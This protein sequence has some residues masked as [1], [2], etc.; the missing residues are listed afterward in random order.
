MTVPLLVGPWLSE[1][2]YEALYWTAFVRWF[3][4]EYEVD[5]GRLV[6]VSRGG[7]GTWYADITSNYVELLDLFA[8]DDFAERNRR[9]LEAGDQKQLAEA[10]FDAEILR[11]LRASG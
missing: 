11:R 10:E 4:R 3:V 7:V 1:V 5:P 9:R 2:G 6:V 8:P